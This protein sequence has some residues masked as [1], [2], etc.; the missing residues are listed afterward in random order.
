MKHTRGRHDSD[1]HRQTTSAEFLCSLVYTRRGAYLV[2]VK[3]FCFLFGSLEFITITTEHWMSKTHKRG[4][5]FSQCQTTPPRRDRTECNCVGVDWKR[6]A[7]SI[8]LT[9]WL[10]PKEAN[11]RRKEKRK[12][13][14]EPIECMNRNESRNDV[15]GGFYFGA[16]R[17]AH[18]NGKWIARAECIHS[19]CSC[20]LHALCV[21]I[22][23][24]IYVSRSAA[25]RLKW[26]MRML[27]DVAFRGGSCMATSLKVSP[28]KL[29]CFMLLGCR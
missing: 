9:D 10:V 1:W 18:T 24:F 7:L 25:V 28:K 27:S 6:A 19:R 11:E 20:S 2:I 22:F 13:N 8:K 17:H 3:A 12:M 4:K 23:A 5:P 15:G 14:C 26:V 16:A 21:F 29:F